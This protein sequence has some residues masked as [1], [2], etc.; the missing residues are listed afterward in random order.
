MESDEERVRR[1]M[2]LIEEYGLD[3]EIVWHRE[4]PVLSLED[5]LKVHGLDPGNVLKCIL[6]KSRR[7]KVVGVI[8]PGDVRIDFKRL[9]RLA[10]FKKL[11]FMSVRE[12]KS[13]FGVEPGGVDPFTLYELADVVYVERTLLEKDFVVGSAG[14]RFC[15]LKAKPGEL[16]EALGATV[17]NLAET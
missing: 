7:D 4:I 10:G 12:M 6:M 13:R 1:I 11:S 16:V 9:E 15:G 5:A 17:I 2:D 8:A 3:A 14:S